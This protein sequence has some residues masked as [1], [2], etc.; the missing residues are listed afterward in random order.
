MAGS[1]DNVKESWNLIR[2]NIKTDEPTKAGKYLGCDHK[3]SEKWVVPGSDPM[4]KDTDSSAA[5]SKL[6]RMMEYDMELFLV[7]CV[8]I[9]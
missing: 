5:K 3:Q 8:E 6:V 2:K 9:H 1:K 4:A 7:Q